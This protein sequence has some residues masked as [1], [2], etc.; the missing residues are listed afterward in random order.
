[1]KRTLCKAI[2]LILVTGILWVNTPVFVYAS[3]TTT[4]V[5]SQIDSISSVNLYSIFYTNYIVTGSNVKRYS[6]PGTNYSV[7]GYLS[8]GDLIQVRSVSDGWAKFIY[9]AKWNYVRVKFL[10]KQ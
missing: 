3:D 5:T 9:N 7:L 10:D 6:G 1:M 4:H 2:I 8:K